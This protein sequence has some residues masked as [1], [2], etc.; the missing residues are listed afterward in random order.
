MSISKT[1]INGN[2]VSSHMIPS[3]GTVTINTGLGNT[4]TTLGNWNIVG[5]SWVT[6]APHYSSMGYTIYSVEKSIEFTEF[7]FKLLDIDMTFE[8]FS[9]M[10]DSEKAAFVRQHVIGNIIK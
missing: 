4:T 7:L 9:T 5:G 2:T 6:T 8:E 3:S 10:D 1:T